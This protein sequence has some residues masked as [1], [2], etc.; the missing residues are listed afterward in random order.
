MKVLASGKLNGNK[1]FGVY[2]TADMDGTD[3]ANIYNKA[4][5][6]GLDAF[7]NQYKGTKITPEKIKKAVSSMGTK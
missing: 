4:E 2:A 6:M 3:R 5:N 1:F 7:V